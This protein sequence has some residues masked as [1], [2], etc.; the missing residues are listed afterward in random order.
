MPPGSLII[1]PDAPKPAVTLIAYSP[2]AFVEQPITHIEELEAFREDWPV[3]WVNVIGLGD[4]ELI[5]ELGALF[6][7][8]RLALEDVVNTHQRAKV[9]PYG[10]HL[11]IVTRMVSR[12]GPFESEQ[13]SC[14]VGADFVLTF[15]ERPG[16]PLDPVRNR[17]RRKWGRVRDMSADYLAYT[18]LDTA[19]DDYFP[20]LEEYGERLETLEEV[21][22]EQPTP[23]ALTAVRG[24]KRDLMA[25]RRALWPQREALNNLSRDTLDPVTQ[26]T[27]VYFRDC[28]DHALRLM[29]LTEHYREHSSDL[30][31]VYLSSLSHRMN[32]VMKTLTVIAAIF[33]PL[34]FLAGIYGMNFD[35]SAS[36]FNMPELYTYWGYPAVLVTM[37]VIALL[38]LWMFR[39]RGWI[40]TA[41][42]DAQPIKQAPDR[43]S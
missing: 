31:D 24:L 6:Q 23:D 4:I 20:T 39:R 32:E 35:H 41:A 16:D 30:M 2:D 21:V 37:L 38:L 34:T 8:H 28:Y 33:I 19:L 18:L 10:N 25:M 27:R 1:D 7:L 9:D 26:E 11:F 13:L 5:K 42:T 3:I 12:R 43:T 15:Q 29:E 17:I 14:F 40:G 36:P 22:L